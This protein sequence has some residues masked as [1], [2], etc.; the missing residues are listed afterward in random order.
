M[1]RISVIIPAYNAQT[2]LNKCVDSILN[3]SFKE[4]EL[5]IVD[6]GSTD[7][8]A[9]ICDEYADR[10]R[11]V[12]V[13]HQ[14]NGG[15]SRARNAG[16]AVASGEL[17]AFVDAD[18]YLVANAYEIMLG[19]MEKFNADTAL[20]NFSAEAPDGSISPYGKHIDGGFY[21]AEQSKKLIVEPLLRDRLTAEF[22]GFIWCYLFDRKSIEK[23][24]IRFT[25]AYL[26]DELFLIEYFSTGRTLAVTDE[27]LYR[28]Y[29]NP[30]SVTR[31]Y[32][33]NYE[34]TFETS[35]KLK[36]ELIKKYKIEIPSDWEYST[37]WA[38]LL[39]AVGNEF[40][41][42]NPADSTKKVK[43][44]RELCRSGIFAP[45]VK[46]YKPKGMGRRKTVVAT[47]IRARQYRLL[48]ALYNAK[49]RNRS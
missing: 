13:I 37:L 40:A 6:D 33:K 1:P 10:D 18:D 36:K 43:K 23:Q 27:S 28:Y 25:G 39:I 48:A 4:F 20:C 14:K 45:A 21:N 34:K 3:Q 17:I 24:G 35:F 8:T 32:L 19:V 22:N 7:D 5:I 31:R 29:L 42:G 30:G 9:K 49:N 46:K 26:E 2:Y 41:P 38:G 47:L 44:L 12:K 11:R 15:V 16:L